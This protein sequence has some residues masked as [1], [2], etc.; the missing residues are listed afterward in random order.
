MDKTTKASAPV[1][2][3]VILPP[4]NLSLETLGI[5]IDWFTDAKIVEVI[6]STVEVGKTLVCSVVSDT[7]PD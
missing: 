6:A 7:Y 4:K 5:P 2:P 1:H 3:H